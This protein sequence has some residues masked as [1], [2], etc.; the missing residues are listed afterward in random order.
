M[1]RYRT[2]FVAIVLA[3]SSYGLLFGTIPVGDTGQWQTAG[4][5]SEPRGGAASVLLF[6]GAVLVTGGSGSAGSVA[7]ADVFGPT[8]EF[9]AV[10]AMRVPRAAHASVVLWD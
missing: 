8:G 9:T 1:A 10:A 6:D 7:T 5:L 2:A 3:A 4:S